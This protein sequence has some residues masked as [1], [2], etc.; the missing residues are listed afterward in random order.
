[1]CK[2]DRTG[3][4]NIRTNSVGL[5]FLQMCDIFYTYLWENLTN[6][7]KIRTIVFCRIGARKST[8]FRFAATTC[9]GWTCR[10]KSA[11]RG[12]LG[13]SK[14]TQPSRFVSTRD[15]CYDFKNIFAEKNC[16]K[17]FSEKICSYLNNFNS[18]NY[19]HRQRI[20]SCRFK[21]GYLL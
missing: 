12:T 7:C 18:Q 1:M 4:T 16:E 5:F 9:S 6:M 15:R 8:T 19:L 21:F 13:S 17:I 10:R 11:A 2:I 3:L 20:Y 14:S